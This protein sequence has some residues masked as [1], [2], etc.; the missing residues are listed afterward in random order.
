MKVGKTIE[1]AAGE[2]SY[3]NASHESSQEGMEKQQCR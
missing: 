3:D 1:G 2:K